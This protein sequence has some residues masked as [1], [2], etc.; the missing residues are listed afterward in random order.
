MQRSV[1][2]HF[3]L[4]LFLPRI[5]YRTIA[6]PSTFCAASWLRSSTSGLVLRAPAPTNEHEAGQTARKQCEEGRFGN[7][8]DSSRNRVERKV[9]DTY[10]KKI[11]GPAVVKLDRM[12]SR[13]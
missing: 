7:R 11:I 1:L 10:A 12:N 6:R 8:R 4:R 13:R 2:P 3:S 9:I 5:N